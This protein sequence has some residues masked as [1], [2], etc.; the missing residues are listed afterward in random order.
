MDVCNAWTAYKCMF[1]QQL[2]GTS[3]LYVSLC[4][5][6]QY[7]VCMLQL[8]YLLQLSISFIYFSVNWVLKVSADK[9]LCSF[10]CTLCFNIWQSSH[11]NN[12]WSILWVLDIRRFIIV[13]YWMYLIFLNNNV[14]IDNTDSAVSIWHLPGKWV[15]CNQHDCMQISM[16]ATRSAWSISAI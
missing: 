14:W 5:V 9:T 11:N 13:I 7:V 3:V 6:W 1:V 8:L 10:H 4:V 12:I 16:L 15:P 2:R